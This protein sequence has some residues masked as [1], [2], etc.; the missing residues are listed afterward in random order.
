MPPGSYGTDVGDNISTAEAV[1]HCGGIASV[2]RGIA[3]VLWRNSI[4]TAEG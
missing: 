1:Q 3:S 2:L 4:S